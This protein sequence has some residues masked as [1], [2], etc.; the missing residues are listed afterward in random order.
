MGRKPTGL[1]PGRRAQRGEP[2]ELVLKF[3]V[4]AAERARIEA[5]AAARG[6]SLS[7]YLRERALSEVS[8]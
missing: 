3:K 2:A 7:A 5:L 4:T 6:L 1:P 8:D